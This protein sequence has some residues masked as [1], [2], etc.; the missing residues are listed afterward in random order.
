[1]SKDIPAN[2]AT[3]RDQFAT[4]V[5]T[6]V[7]AN[8]LSSGLDYADYLDAARDAYKVADAMLEVRK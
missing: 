6:G 7:F 8:Q 2:E 3:L 4:A 5:L 1:M